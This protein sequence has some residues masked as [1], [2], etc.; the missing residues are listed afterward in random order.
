[1]EILK[2][3]DKVE[4]FLDALKAQGRERVIMLDYDG[5]LAPFVVDRNRAIPYPGIVELLDEILT[6]ENNKLIIVT[7]RNAREIL[8]LLPLR[9][10]FEIFGGHGSERLARNGKLS[11]VPLDNSVKQAFS[12]FKRWAECQGLGDRTEVKHGALAFHVRGMPHDAALALLDKARRKM[13]ELKKDLELE[14]RQFD[15]GIEMRTPGTHKGKVVRTVVSETN[16]S[17][18]ITYLGDDL[19]DE[20]AFRALGDRGV[21]V[22]VRPVF[23][24]T[25]ADV[26]ITPP[27]ELKEWLSRFILLNK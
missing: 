22:L 13:I 15:G 24:K 11:K 16:P 18:L 8:D 23:R 3:R 19:T 9:H 27:D 25:A 21:S 6:H 14:I 5:T 2:A 1:M 10:P 26:W 7:G 17:A 12:M 4:S 20:D